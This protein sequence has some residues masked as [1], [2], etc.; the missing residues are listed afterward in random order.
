[1]AHLMHNS[2]VPYP[3][4]RLIKAGAHYGPQTCDT[5]FLNVFKTF[6]KVY[7]YNNYTII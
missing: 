2:G 5:N 7:V 4:G 3:E 6:E 1:M